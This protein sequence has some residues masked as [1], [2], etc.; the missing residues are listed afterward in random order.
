MK[1]G[2]LVKPVLF[3]KLKYVLAKLQKQKTNQGNFVKRPE[4][5]VP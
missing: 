4:S 1:G 2:R 5:I 3:S